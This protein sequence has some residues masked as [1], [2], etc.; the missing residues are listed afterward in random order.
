[1]V[2]A[3]SVRGTKRWD[4]GSTSSTHPLAGPKFHF[5]PHFFTT[6]KRE[7]PSH[8]NVKIC[9]QNHSALQLQKNDDGDDY[10]DDKVVVE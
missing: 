10:T 7:T 3:H 5:W 6:E 4:L 9:S 1:M 8:K 2:L